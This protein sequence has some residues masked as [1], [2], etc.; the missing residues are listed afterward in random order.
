MNEKL[1]KLLFIALFGTII[2]LI[3]KSGILENTS[4]TAIRDLLMTYGD[5]API[6][7]IILFTFV[8]LTL[9]PDSVLAIA[10]GLLFGFVKGCLYTMIGA[11]FGAT[12][13]FFISRYLGR[14]WIES[15]FSKEESKFTKGISD[16]GFVVVLALRLIPLLPFDVVSY[17]SGL[18]SIRYKDYMLATMVGIIPGVMV[19]TNIGYNAIDVSSPQ[20]YISIA[21]L[22]LLA[23]SSKLAKDK[24]DHWISKDKLKGHQIVE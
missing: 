5:L 15:K 7:Y 6:I 17:L 10:A 11:A 3:T 21:L 4:A 19:F 24:L 20:F 1:K 8:P 13:A 23:L 22:V 18:S 9:F 2:A 14:D 16:K 12:L